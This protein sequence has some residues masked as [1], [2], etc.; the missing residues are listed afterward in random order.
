M[1]TT[2]Q[3]GYNMTDLFW[4]IFKKS[5]NIDAFLAYKEFDTFK[6]AQESINKD[7]CIETDV[8]LSSMI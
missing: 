3:E 6:Q 2:F 5:G 1:R 8:K 4:S 7:N